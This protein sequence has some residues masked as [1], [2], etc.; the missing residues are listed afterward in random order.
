LTVASAGG[1]DMD[2]FDKEEFDMHLGDEDGDESSND[3]SV[4]GKWKYSK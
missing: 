2:W 4:M 3:Q 1:V